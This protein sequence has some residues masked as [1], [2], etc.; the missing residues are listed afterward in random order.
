MISSGLTRKIGNQAA[1]PPT[2]CMM[3]MDIGPL[4]TIHFPAQ[5]FLPLSNLMSEIQ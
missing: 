2:G 4:G 1:W 3:F 5:V